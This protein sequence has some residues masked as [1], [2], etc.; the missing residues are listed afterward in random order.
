MERITAERQ[1]FLVTCHRARH[2]ALAEWDPG[3]WLAKVR[4]VELAAVGAAYR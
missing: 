1:V 4:W 2:R 3:S